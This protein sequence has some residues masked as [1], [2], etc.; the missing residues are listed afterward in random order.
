M[1]RNRFHAYS[2]NADLFSLLQRQIK[3]NQR[4]DETADFTH[5]ISENASFL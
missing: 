1:L 3:I 4:Q 2:S 5:F